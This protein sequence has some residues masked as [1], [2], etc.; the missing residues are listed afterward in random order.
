ME[1][2]KIKEQLL[3]ELIAA[4]KKLEERLEI[5]EQ[6]IKNF[7]AL[8]ANDNLFVKII[9]FFPYPIAVFSPEGA[10]ET[11]NNSLLVEI[12][13]SHEDFIAYNHNVFSDIGTAEAGILE[14]IKRALGG[15][16]VSLFD[17]YDPLRS[18]GY[19]Y[20][21]MKQQ[22]TSRGYDAVFFPIKNGGEKTL[23]AVL[24]LFNQKILD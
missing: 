9:D 24:V 20:G 22:D 4:Q 23:H 14:A 10:I 2:H 21:G 11:V 17:L 5:Q 12:G 7:E 8:V 19:A 16:T 18:L 1:E 6:G 3:K 15:E 13:V